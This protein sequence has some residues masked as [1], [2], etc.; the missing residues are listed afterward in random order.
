MAVSHAPEP[1]SPASQNALIA[2]Y[3]VVC[4]NGE[5]MTGNMSLE[6]YDVL[7]AVRHGELT[8]KM[9]RKMAWDGR[10]PFVKVGSL[11]RFRPEDLESFIEAH[12]TAAAR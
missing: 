12:L 8:E 11:L 9:I 6:A 1:M 10:L 2:D 4:H 3:C 5:T 7:E